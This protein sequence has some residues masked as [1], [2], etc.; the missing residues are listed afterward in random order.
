MVTKDGL[1][2]DPGLR[3]GEADAA[4]LGSGEGVAAA[5]DDAGRRP[6]IV[7][8]T[9]GYMSPE[10]AAGEP[11]DFRSDQFSFGSILYEMATGKRAFQKETA[12]RHAG[13]DPA[14]GARADRRRSTRR[15]PAPLRWIVERCLAK[16]PRRALRVDGGPGARPRDR[17]R[18]S[19]RGDASSGA[20]AAT[21]TPPV[22][23]RLSRRARAGVAIAVAIGALLAGRRLGR[24]ARCRGSSSSL[25][26]AATSS[27]ARFSPDGHTIVYS[28]S[29]GRRRPR[30]LLDAAR[31]PRVAVRWRIRGEHPL[32]LVGGRD[33]ASSRPRP[34]RSARA[35]AAR[36]R[37]AA[38]APEGRSVRGLGARRKESR[39]HPSRRGQ[40]SAWSIRSGRSLRNRR[41]GSATCTS[42]RREIASLSSK[43]SV[44][45][46]HTPADVM[47]LD[48]G[49][50]EDD[51]RRG[52]TAHEFAW[53]PDGD[54]ICGH[55]ADRWG[56]CARSRRTRPASELVASVAGIFGLDDV[57]RD[58]R[59]AAERIDLRGRYAGRLPASD[60]R[61]ISPGS[62][63]SMRPALSDDGKTVLDQRE[64]RQTPSTFARRTARRDA[65]RARDRPSRSPRTG[66]GHSSLRRNP[67][68]SS[69]SCRR[70]Q[71]RRACSKTA[72][73][74]LRWEEVCFPDG[75]RILFSG[76]E[77]G[78]R[79]RLYVMDVEGGSPGRSARKGRSRAA[80]PI[81]SPDGK[82]VCRPRPD[83]RF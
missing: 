21:A 71:D 43:S 8:G 2:Q 37:S 61:T 1:R 69:S 75:K 12:R 4:G 17:S 48:I 50:E 30:A 40:S 65:A 33:G 27:A 14:R 16:E 81:V 11:V 79:P 20:V 10:Q 51:N 18:S 60:K 3:P 46:M 25:S 66:S 42:R 77:T 59:R 56:S 54:E 72:G 9:V 73:R 22:A 35:G 45:S 62:I 76:T 7:I 44:Q 5:D 82:L 6:G 36:R 28:A 39:R 29:V 64:Q 23:A 83:Q 49:D 38:G 80:R 32:D 78:Q 19:L 57:A 55:S 15:L 70:A 74:E 34:V 68:H 47:L 31:K 26:A 53:S 24:T 52:S 63:P 41:T 58:G 67:L 13:G